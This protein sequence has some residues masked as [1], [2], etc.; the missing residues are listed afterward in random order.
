MTPSDGGQR[1]GLWMVG[2][3][4]AI[5]TCVAYG[6][7][8]MR[9]GLLAPTGMVTAG[10]D[11]TELDLVAPEDLVLGGHDVCRR[12]LSQSAGELVRSGV[13]TSDLV[14][15]CSRE[16]AAFEARIRPGVLDAPDVGLGD[17]DPMVS[18]T[19]ARSSR[20]QVA[21]LVADIDAFAQDAEL[22]RVVVVYLASTE[23]CREPQPE[24]SELGAFESAL[25]QGR[26]QPASVLYAYAALSSGR[27][28]VNFTPSLGARVPALL[29]L[30]EERGVP[31]CGNDAKTGETLI[32]TALAPTFAKRGLNVLAWQGYNMLGNRDGEV[33]R[34]EA[35]R[36]AKLEN[37]DAALRTLL[38]ASN[39][40][41][42]KVGIDYVPSLGDWKTAWDYV[43][44]EGFLGARMSLQ[45]TWSGSDSALAA[46]LV[47]DLARLA[48]LASRKGESGVMT[49]TAAFFKDPLAGGS[50]DFHRQHEA[51]LKYVR[52][53]S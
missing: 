44:F 5:S 29:Q 39:Q 42:T 34:D 7:A 53:R 45:F 8:G 51:L 2:A 41:H 11:F 31:H 4:G 50:H 12:S 36:Q 26:P 46:P 37:K 21:G 13:L 24:W 14:A 3:R 20:D 27:P 1:V 16:A 35:H 52:A 40:L 32:K 38:P 49:H 18:E 9:E 33:L 19:S 25:E 47:I 17:L 23:A 6:L 43:H 22:E 30:A 10:S 15:A 48:E 28:F